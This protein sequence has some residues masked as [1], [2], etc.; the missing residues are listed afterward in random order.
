MFACSRVA[1]QHPLCRVV[2][3]FY[4]YYYFCSL[5]APCVVHVCA[6]LPKPSFPVV[7]TSYEI[8]IADVKFLQ[9]YKWKYI[10][11]DEGH[12]LK[13]S[14]CKLLRELRSIP[15]ANK[16]LLSGLPALPL[17]HAFCPC[18]SPAA[19]LVPPPPVCRISWRVHHGLA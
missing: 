1:R 16:I 5:A 3:L 15:T 13:N 17:R 10:V 12:R 4:Y 11:V 14:N 8:V 19:A 9:K 7:V 6:G 18:L 2:L